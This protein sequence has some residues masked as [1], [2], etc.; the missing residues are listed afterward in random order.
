MENSKKEKK[1]KSYSCADMNFFILSFLNEQPRMLSACWKSTRFC[2]RW[3]GSNLFANL[4]THFAHITPLLYPAFVCISCIILLFHLSAGKCG[5]GMGSLY[6]MM[7][8]DKFWLR[9]AKE[10]GG[11]RGA[12]SDGW[13]SCWVVLEDE[14]ISAKTLSQ[15]LPAS[16]RMASIL[17]R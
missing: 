15:L 13:G 8:I 7:T 12:Y 11:R 14:S 2:R 10:R 5:F 4:P 9:G 17:R 16:L 3:S 1:R 6:I